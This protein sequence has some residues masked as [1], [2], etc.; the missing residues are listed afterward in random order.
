MCGYGGKRMVKVRILNDKGTK[1]FAYL[2]VDGYEPDTNT[3]YQ[4]HGCYWHGHT[5][6]ENRTKTQKLRYKDSVR[7]IGL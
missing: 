7:S 2:S 4:F 3:V 6:I 5:C 1:T